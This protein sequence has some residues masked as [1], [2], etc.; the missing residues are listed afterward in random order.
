MYVRVFFVLFWF[1]G[2][3]WGI[4]VPCSASRSCLSVLCNFCVVDILL[5]SVYLVQGS[6][7]IDVM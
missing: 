6:V 5:L 7:R 1:L 3:R 4:F 2:F